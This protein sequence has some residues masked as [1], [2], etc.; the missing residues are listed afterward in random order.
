MEGVILWSV[1]TGCALL[2]LRTGILWP[3]SHSFLPVL[4]SSERGDAAQRPHRMK[5]SPS[6]KTH[7]PYGGVQTR[8]TETVHKKKKKQIPGQGVKEGTVGNGGWTDLQ[9][10]GEECH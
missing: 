2:R 8:K 9:R 3:R 10:G 5:I 7:I 1:G 6:V 4:V